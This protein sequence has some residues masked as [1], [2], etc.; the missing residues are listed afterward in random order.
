M[1][2]AAPEVSV[3]L[4]ISFKVIELT[5]I[6]T[7]VNDQLI[8]NIAIHSCESTIALGKSGSE[9]VEIFAAHCFANWG[10]DGSLAVKIWQ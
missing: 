3:L 2:R 5:L 8:A 9:C 7:V 4:W 6:D 10:I 1:V